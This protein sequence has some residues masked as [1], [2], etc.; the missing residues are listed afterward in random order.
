MIQ[1]NLNFA[2]PTN[3]ELNGLESTLERFANYPESTIK[4]EIISRLVG[5]VGVQG[6]TFRLLTKASLTQCQGTFLSSTSNIIQSLEKLK[7]KDLGNIKPDLMISE[8]VKE[9]D[10][11]KSGYKEIST[12]LQKISKEF[13]SHK[14]FIQKE[15]NTL[16]QSISNLKYLVRQEKKNYIKTGLIFGFGIGSVS[17]ATTVLVVPQY[18]CGLTLF[19][20]ILTGGILGWYF[21][22]KS[23]F[24]LREEVNIKEQQLGQLNQN[25]QY[26]DN[27][28]DNVKLFKDGVNLFETFWNRHHNHMIVT[29]N[30]ISNARKGTAQISNLSVNSI[31]ISWAH[32]KNSLDN[33]EM[34]INPITS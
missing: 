23:C 27:V 14:S 13:Q 5:E 8:L 19:A 10:L 18:D 1:T 7:T 4:D 11:I 24:K 30:F 12:S 31:L 25:S 2:Y 22:N 26:I 33:Y 32:A 21:G 29:Q 9:Y 28:M 34:T 6:R 15:Q 3:L 17:S 16:T 20:S